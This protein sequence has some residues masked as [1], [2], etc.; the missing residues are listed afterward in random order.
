MHLNTRVQVAA[1]LAV[2]ALLG[3]LATTGKVSSPLGADE[4][5]NAAPGKAP[6]TAAAP[7]SPGKAA[8]L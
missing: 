1:A 4:G 2:G 6:E 7:G 5:K 8:V 3:Y